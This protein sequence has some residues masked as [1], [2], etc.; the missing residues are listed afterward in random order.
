MLVGIVRKFQEF[1]QNSLL[2][3]RLV[4]SNAIII[5]VCLF[6]KIADICRRVHRTLFNTLISYPFLNFSQKYMLLNT[7][8]IFV[9]GVF[10]ILFMEFED[11]HEEK[12]RSLLCPR[13]HRIS[14]NFSSGFSF[15]HWA[16]VRQ[17][18]EQFLPEFQ[19]NISNALANTSGS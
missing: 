19:R 8:C 6:I 16:E 3:S 1:D 2:F 4:L 18:A 9:V 5:E 11:E 7:H 10:F 14:S 13:Y 17:R 15:S 12:S